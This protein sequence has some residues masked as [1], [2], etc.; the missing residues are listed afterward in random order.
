[1]ILADALV[2]EACARAGSDDFGPATWREGLEVG[3]RE[4]STAT[5]ATTSTPELVNG[6]WSGGSTA[7]RTAAEGQRPIRRHTASMR[8]R[9]GLSSPST[10]TG[11][12]FRWTATVPG[13]CPYPANF[14]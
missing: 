7:R 3:N 1:M 10:T 4:G 14:K 2:E 6:W 12:P 5:W 9:S 13:E 8:S 11:L